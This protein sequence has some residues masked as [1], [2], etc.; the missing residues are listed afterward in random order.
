M[1]S[2]NET[3][4]RLKFIS[5]INKGEKINS[6]HLF[7]QT[8][9]FLTRLSRMFYNKDNRINTFNFI[10]ETIRDALDLIKRFQVSEKISEKMLKDNI[11][12]DL[13]TSIQGIL[14]IKDTYAE[15]IKLGCDIDTLIQYLNASLSEIDSD[16]KSY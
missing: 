3:I 4:S 5:K 1:E 9:N 13:K 2:I 6:R 14:N 15:D 11:V 16:K 7:V 10:K 8:D 12:Q